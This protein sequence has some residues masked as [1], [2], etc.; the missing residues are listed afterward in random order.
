MYI[1]LTIEATNSGFDRVLMAIKLSG[2]MIEM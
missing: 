2:L 1:Q